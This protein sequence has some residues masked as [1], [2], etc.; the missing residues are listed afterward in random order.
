VR[1]SQNRWSFRP[2]VQ[3]LRSPSRMMIMRGYQP[4]RV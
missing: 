3:S 4:L 1:H 2:P